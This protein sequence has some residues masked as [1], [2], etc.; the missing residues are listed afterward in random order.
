[1]P[2]DLGVLRRLCREL[3]E[4]IES[5]PAPAAGGPT[6]G[7]FVETLRLHLEAKILPELE[8]DLDWPIFV[9]VQGGTN[10]GK[11]TL[12]NALAGKLLS[13]A[14]ILASAT[15]HPLVFV[16]ERWRPRFLD[17]GE[18][19][20]FA[21]RELEDPREL[22]A[23]AER[24]DLL[25]FRF[26]ADG[27]LD[28]LA[29]ID[30]P[31]LDSAL[32]TNA[33]VARRV[34]ALSD[35]AI[36]VTTPQKYRD[37]ELVERLRD[38]AQLKVSTLLLFN[39]TDETIVFETLVD[40]LRG[41]VPLDAGAF[42]ALRI[43]TVKAQHPEDSI[44]EWLRREVFS[45]LEGYDARAVKRASVGRALE[46]T[47]ADAERLGEALS[48]QLELRER[49]ESHLEAEIESAAADYER[50]FRL[51]LPEE[52]LAIRRL[53]RLGELWT[54]LELPEAARGA[55]RLLAL[56]SAGLRQL[57]EGWRNA[58]L[59]LIPSR[60][61]TVDESPAALA[62][63]ARSRNEEDCREV[64]RAADRCR[65]A[66]EE[67]LRTREAGSTV[68]QHVR[69]QF[70]G[71]GRFEP[72]AQRVREAFE[73]EAALREG[74]EDVYEKVSSWCERHPA[75]ARLAGAAAIA[76]KAGAGIVAAMV[77]PPDGVLSVLN[78]L[79]FA[80]GYGL[81][82]YLLALALS[83]AL[84][85]RDRFRRA[86]RR[87]LRRVLEAALREPL[88]QS[89][90]E[91]IRAKDLAQLRDRTAALARAGVQGRAVAEEGG[92]VRRHD[93]PPGPS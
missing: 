79:Y 9:A 69:S 54:Y 31:D 19:A 3:H 34:A 15:K 77:L 60:E 23:D 83:L 63:Y 21:C 48:R 11:S 81:G 2:P 80:A 36:F 57:Q 20:G 74:G 75:A 39:F 56:L 52:T 55:S 1:M 5:L 53:L 91:A 58:L 41:T 24:T 12:F 7:G 66:V 10:V 51:A 8:A 28:S 17:P 13:P 45:I 25:F 93:D 38:L 42:R 64:Q 47:A 27:A 61:G 35:L 82:A 40:D 46:R 37:R 89:L 16:H 59:K 22:I 85:R 84:R 14:T 88:R 18:L 90:D 72:L 50:S 33:L 4:L 30:S 68:A 44:G 43:P 29:L 32:V 76:A 62:D 49:L 71:G 6:G 87:A 65:H 86:R 26:H 70:F 73:R 78:L 92:A 67:F